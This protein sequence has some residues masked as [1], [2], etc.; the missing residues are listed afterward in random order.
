MFYGL[1]LTV[2]M[3]TGFPSSRV[4]DS[5]IPYLADRPVGAD[6]YYMLT[7]AWNIAEKGRIVYNYDLTVTG[8]QP[9]STFVYAGFA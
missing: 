7:V 1:A 8:I 6:A 4:T 9:L 2:L 5:K 3:P